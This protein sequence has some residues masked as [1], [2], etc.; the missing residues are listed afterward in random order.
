MN[1]YVLPLLL[2]SA[3]AFIFLKK[4]NIMKEKQF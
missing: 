3:S 4:K 2:A 1:K